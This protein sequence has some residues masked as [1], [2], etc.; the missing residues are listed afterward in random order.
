M[1][2][3]TGVAVLVAKGGAVNISIGRCKS[4]TD[5]IIHTG[6]DKELAT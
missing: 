3:Q 1:H 5:N 6:A 4:N 2:D